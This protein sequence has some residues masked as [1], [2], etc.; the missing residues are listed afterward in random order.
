MSRDGWTQADHEALAVVRPRQANG[1]WILG[2][3]AAAL[4]LVA[5]LVALLLAS[6][7]WAACTSTTVG[8]TTIYNCEGSVTTEQRAGP[9]TSYQPKF[10]GEDNKPSWR[11]HSSDSRN[12]S[13]ETP[14]QKP[15]S[16]QRHSRQ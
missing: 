1:S 4:M 9:Y 8:N 6:S 5:V 15:Y 10:P 14:R 11:R 12:V 7:A 13:R 16:W 2:L 3:V